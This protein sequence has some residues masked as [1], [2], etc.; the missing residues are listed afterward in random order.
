M[1]F[2]KEFTSNSCAGS[3]NQFFF[4]MEE[5]E[6]RCGRVFYKLRTAGKFRYSLLFS[7]ILD[8][9]YADGSVGNCNLICDSWEILS[10]RIGR[11]K[12]LEK[13]SFT[14]DAE[15]AYPVVSLEQV[16]DFAELTFGASRQ[17]T[18]APGEFFASDPVELAFEAGEY[19]CLEMTFR[20]TMIPYH[21]E[22]IIPA[23]V[24]TK[25]GWQYCKHV[26]FAGMIG[27]DRPV[28]ARIAYLGD[29]ITQG[30]GTDIDSYEHWNA[31]LSDMVGGEYACW[32][33]GIGF[34]RANDAASNGA[35]L[36][37]AKQNDYVVVCY[38]VNDLSRKPEA[39]IKQD[40]GLIVDKLHEIGAKVLLQTLP[41]FDY[42]G[43]MIGLWK[44]INEY[45]LTELSKKA[46]AVFDVVPILGQDPAAPQ[47][48]SF[49]GHPDKYG[50]ALWAQK[51][52][53]VLKELLDA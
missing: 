33:L 18:V 26:P 45:I 19:L 49:G 8:S 31:K 11:C 14:P 5:D 1:R 10:A 3:G 32:N 9:T 36:Y 12:C 48:A 24:Q 43:E 13:A 4:R 23:F 21:E 29:S 47:K 39:Q 22:S 15:G 52:Y 40:L 50:C 34:G 27:C 44:R 20:G 35:W 2:F 25:G 41:P 38:G 17:K 53:P 16:E 42:Q 30:I 7:N 28:K 6:V 37:K 46:D 51:L